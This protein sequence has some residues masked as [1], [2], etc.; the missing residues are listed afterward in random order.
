VDEDEKALPFAES[1]PGATG[2]EL[3]LSVAVKW[4]RDH[5]VPLN[6]ALQA[7]TA[8]PVAVLGAALGEQQAQLGLLQAGGVADLCIVDPAAEWT[9][10]PKALLSQGKSTP[11]GG[12]ELPARVRYT[13][14]D[15]QIAFERAA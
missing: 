7:V 4:S 13:L 10:E 3:L 6:R 5:G 1:E 14:V 15:G 8:S 12:Y 9:V 2:V 11:F